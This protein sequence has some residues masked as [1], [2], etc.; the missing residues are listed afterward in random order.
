[1]TVSVEVRHQVSLYLRWIGAL[2]GT[3]MGCLLLCSASLY[4]RSKPLS[5]RL[6]PQDITLAG[7]GASQHVM[8]LAECADGLERDVTAQSTLSVSQPELARIDGS[9]TLVAQVSNGEFTLTAA[10]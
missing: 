3:I 8:L 6:L 2:G 5:D 4:A 9:G 10:Y 1:M 7:K